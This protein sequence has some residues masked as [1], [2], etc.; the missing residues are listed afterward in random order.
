MN[1]SAQTAPLML[2]L[3]LSIIFIPMGQSYAIDI[4][5]M[6]SDSSHCYDC[7]DSIELFEDH[8]VDKT[9]MLDSC[10]GSSSVAFYFNPAALVFSPVEVKIP[11][12]G[13]L[14]EFQSQ[15]ITPLYRPPIT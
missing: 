15:H 11:G 7:E 2:L 8:C 14:P 12:F 3:F 13:N 6:G 9:C 4:N 1:Y 10:I 5:V